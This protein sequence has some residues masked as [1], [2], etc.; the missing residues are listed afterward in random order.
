MSRA[1]IYQPQT[2]TYLIPLTQDYEATVD[3]VDVGL[4]GVLWM[5][6]P[7]PR[8]VY[9]YRHTPCV[10][11]KR[12]MVL[13]HRVILAL[14]LDRDLLAN[15]C[16]DHI[17]GKGLDNTRGN[18]R[19]ATPAENSANSRKPR[20]NTSGLTGVCWNK[21]AGK[22]SARIM[23]ND[24]RIHLGYY[25]SKDEAHSAYNAAAE[26]HFGEFANNGGGE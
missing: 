4:T 22:W 3:A 1:A 26:K 8:T 21:H 24:T 15:E 23:V 10:N 16:V 12:E 5:A 25:T 2:D 11:G 6:K 17:N 13:M 14:M 9:A 18:L 7:Y 20:N 19:L